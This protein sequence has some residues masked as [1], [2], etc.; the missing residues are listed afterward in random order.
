ME[1]LVDELHRIYRLPRNDLY[2]AMLTEKMK[3][4]IEFAP[5]IRRKVKLLFSVRL[6]Y[7]AHVICTA[8]SPEQLRPAAICPHVRLYAPSICLDS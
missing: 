1:K 2:R 7:C 3:L 4:F 6:F 8:T 5:F